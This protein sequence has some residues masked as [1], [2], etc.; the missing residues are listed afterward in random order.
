MR[1]IY[2]SAGWGWGL[3]GGAVTTSKGGIPIREKAYGKVMA[4]MRIT[5]P[6]LIHL[7]FNLNSALFLECVV[8]AV[9]VDSCGSD[10]LK[11]NS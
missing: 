7:P 9:L 6:L 8:T 3:P 2:R 4:D 11:H 10:I 5:I 1:Q